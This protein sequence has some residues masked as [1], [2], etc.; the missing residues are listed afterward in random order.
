LQAL[1]GLKKTTLKK[2][3]PDEFVFVL[4]RFPLFKSQRIPFIANGFPPVI[5]SWVFLLFVFGVETPTSSFEMTP[6]IPSF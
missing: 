4:L 5:L 2:V 3:N 6:K 1:G